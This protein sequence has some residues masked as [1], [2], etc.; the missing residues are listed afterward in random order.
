[1]RK[2]ELDKFRKLLEAARESLLEQSARTAGE[3]RATVSEG[4]ED[5]VDDAVTH[6]TR[7]FLLSLSDLERRQLVRVEEALGRM[8]QGEYGECINCGETIGMKRL[9][10]IPWASLCV[11]CQELAEREELAE[12]ALRDLA[13][14]ETG[15]DDSGESAARSSS[16]AGDDGDD[17]DDA[18]GADVAGVR[19]SRLAEKDSSEE[20]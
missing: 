8:R 16:D 18:D 5:Y 13:Q 20:E 1:M 6:Y 4:G 2:R 10:A 19:S 15:E 12:H 17:S 11:R 7:E 3:G 9:Q 14:E